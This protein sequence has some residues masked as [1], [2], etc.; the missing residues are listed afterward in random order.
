MITKNLTVNFE[1]GLNSKGA[2]KLIAVTGHF[3]SKVLI[4]SDNYSINGK[5]IMGVLSLR[6]LQG[7]ELTFVISGKDEKEAA[8]A[9][10]NFMNTGIV[11]DEM[12]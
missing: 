12:L 5:S 9:I 6:A 4:E 11:P 2:V 8:A 3:E 1:N 7:D 10:E